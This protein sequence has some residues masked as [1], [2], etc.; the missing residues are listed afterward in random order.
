MPVPP[1]TAPREPDQIREV[2]LSATAKDVAAYRTHVQKVFRPIDTA[3][4]LQEEWAVPAA[5]VVAICLE[6]LRE[7]DAYLGV[8]GFR[9]GWIP[10]NETRSI[11]EIECD[12]ALKQWKQ[13]T[14]PPV[15]LFT[16]E[17]G[18]T[19]AEDLEAEAA[20]V[21][22]EDFPADETKRAE[23]RRRQ[24]AFCQRLRGSGRVVASFSSQVDLG[25]RA[26]ACVSNWNRDILKHAL[27]D[28]L[29]AAADIPSSVLGTIGRKPQRDALERALLGVRAANVPGMCVV[30]HGAEDTGQFAFLSFL[31]SW[32]DWEINGR[33]RRITPPHDRFDA[34]SVVAAALAE[35]ADAQPIATAAATPDEL[36]RVL[37]AR[38]RDEPVVLMLPHVDRMTGG[39][40]AFHQDVWTPI[41]AAARAQRQAVGAAHPFS[42]VLAVTTPQRP[43]LE[44][45]L[46]PGMLDAPNVDWDRLLLL[47]ELGAFTASD[48]REWLETYGVKLKER[49]EIANRVTKDGV[50]RAVFDR[51]NGENLWNRIN[52]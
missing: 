23:S 49:T 21:L 26:Q 48:I 25:S 30:V 27:R 37:V 14:V 4:F 43:P 6:R 16:P 52:R 8:F 51:L 32:D 41:M 36:A 22:A 13:A 39:L 24:L 47:P 34:T 31:E 45:S 11:T 28:R 12:G 20:R 9:Y 40:S 10:E 50:P 29:A 44:A 42:A 3:V 5:G 18:S 17:P 33:P 1:R 2:F 35:L 19:A 38:C 7:S 46:W 15:F